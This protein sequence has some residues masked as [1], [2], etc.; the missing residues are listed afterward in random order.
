MSLLLVLVLPS[1]LRLQAAAAVCAAVLQQ[2]ASAVLHQTVEA[3]SAM[4]GVPINRARYHRWEEVERVQA[5]AL[6]AAA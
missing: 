4:G 6:A 1:L 2:K 5:L 3:L